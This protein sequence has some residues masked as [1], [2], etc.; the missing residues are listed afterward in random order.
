MS[1]PV[2]YKRNFFD[3]FPTPKFLEMPSVG[4]DISDQSIRF[5]EI[6]RSR[7]GRQRF[8]LKS[9]GEKKI[10]DA[11]ITPGFINKPEDV[12]KNLIEIRKKHGFRFANVSLPEEKGYLFKT[13]LPNFEER[14]F[15]ENIELRLEENV[16]LDVAKSI[17]DYRLIQ[18]SDGVRR[19][20]V[21]VTVVPSKV[22]NVYGELFNSAS[23]VP[24][25]YE[26]VTQAVARAIVPQ[27]EMETCLIIY[28][29]DVRTGFGI[30]SRGA[31]Q[32]TST[33]NVGRAENPADVEKR[34]SLLKDEIVKLKSYWQGR[35]ENENELIKKVIVSGKA[36]VTP[37][38]KESLADAA[39]CSVDLANVW[40]NVFSLN[41]HIPEM[42]LEESLDYAPAIGLAIS[43]FYHA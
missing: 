27:D 23:I 22:I 13:E 7:S 25:S 43:R 33:V 42:S 16:P 17:F 9:F 31:L 14:Y 6:V 12:V 26:L 35:N 10:P 36:A 40:T 3:F 21:I 30:V 41:E 29:G 38:L 11:S 15:A 19:N 39:G 5:V 32:F 4:I 24:V 18:S 2:H 37:G 20:E 1:T 28:V 34:Q 8:H